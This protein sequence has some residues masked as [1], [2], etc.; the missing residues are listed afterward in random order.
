MVVV[1]VVVLLVE[2]YVYVTAAGLLVTEVAA[3]AVAARV[4][5]PGGWASLVGGA[6]F[7][8]SESPR[9]PAR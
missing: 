7:A 6:S 1:V 2:Q 9:L 3:V 8:R 4:S 5:V